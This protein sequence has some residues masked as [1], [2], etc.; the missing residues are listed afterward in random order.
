MNRILTM[1][2]G[3]ACAGV[4]AGLAVP[5]HAAPE[6]TLT[7]FECGTP[8]APIAVNQRFSDTYAYGDLKLQ[9]VPSCYL[10]KHGDEYLLWDTGHAM[11]MPNVAPKVSLLDLL[12]QIAIQARADQICWHQPLSRRSHR[13]GQLVSKGDA[14]DRK[15]RLGCH[16]QSEAGRRRKLQAVR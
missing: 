12:A 13:P 8:Q 11:T 7:R 14:A 1:L 5:A 10:V 4:L 16:H 6:I 3:G 15:G 2:A 9:L